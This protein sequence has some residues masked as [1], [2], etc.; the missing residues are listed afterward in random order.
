MHEVVAGKQQLFKIFLTLAMTVHYHSRHDNHSEQLAV[1]VT[2]DLNLGSI[3]FLNLS[4][5]T[6]CPDSCCGFHQSLK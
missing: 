2:L 1:M 5:V 6:S 3:F 4:K